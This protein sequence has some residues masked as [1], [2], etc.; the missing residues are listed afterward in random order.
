M[1]FFS[2]SL[3][4]AAVAVVVMHSHD[5]DV[6]VADVAVES[7]PP[8]R[9]DVALTSPSWHSVTM[10]HVCKLP[11]FAPGHHHQHQVFDI[12]FVS[13]SCYRHHSILVVCFPLLPPLRP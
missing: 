3:D 13:S 8:T 7:W 11:L 4:L 2:S 1:E 9:L 10:G 5:V 12:L 6:D